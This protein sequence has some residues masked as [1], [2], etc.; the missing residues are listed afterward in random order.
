M[1]YI[2]SPCSPCTQLDHT[3]VLL[4]GQPIEDMSVLARLQGPGRKVEDQIAPKAQCRS[5][6][7]PEPTAQESPISSVCEGLCS[8]TRSSPAFS[9]SQH[10][11]IALFST[12]DRGSFL[13]MQVIG[14]IA[15]SLIVVFGPLVA[16]GVMGC[17]L[18][19]PEVEREEREDEAESGGSETKE[20]DEES[21]ARDREGG[22]RTENSKQA[23]RRRD[24][25]FQEVA[26]RVTDNLNG[27]A[28]E[29]KNGQEVSTSCTTLWNS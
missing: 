14:Y 11:K 17:Q 7:N 4:F 6:T 15:M 2:H 16:I 23:I 26:K 3:L 20:V 12:A 21:S 29:E 1:T 25:F 28:Q 27:T 9:A 24:A 22:R 10:T 19:G 13:G 8:P 5:A 18:W